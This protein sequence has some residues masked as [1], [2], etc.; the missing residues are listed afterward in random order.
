M[1]GHDPKSL[2]PLLRELG[3]QE[4]RI[5]DRVCFGGL[6]LTAFRCFEYLPAVLEVTPQPNPDIDGFGYESQLYSR[7]GLCSRMRERHTN[8]NL[9]DMTSLQR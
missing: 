7:K 8:E 3:I 2:I 5:H 1:F 4:H 9:C 6:M